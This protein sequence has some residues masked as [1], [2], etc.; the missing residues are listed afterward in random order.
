[1]ASPSPS[2]LLLA[3]L[4]LP[5][6]AVRLK[7]RPAGRK[8][9]M[10]EPAM[11]AGLGLL[12][13]WA[14]FRYPG[15]RPG[16]LVRAAVHGAVS[17]AGF[18]L[19]PATLSFLLPFLPSHALQ[20]YVVPSLLIATLTYVLLSWVWLIA[21]LVDDLLGG[22]PRGGI[23]FQASPSTRATVRQGGGRRPGRRRRGNPRP[24]L[25][26]ASALALLERSPGLRLTLLEKEADL[27]L[28]QSG[29]NSGVIHAG[30]YYPP[31]SLKA[32]FWREGR[33][34]LEVFCQ[35]HAVP[36]RRCGKFVV[37]IDES[38]L[39][40]LAELNRRGAANG[41]EGL[42][43]LDQAGMRAI[44]PHVR[45]IRGLHA[46]ETQLSTFVSSPRGWPTS[47]EAEAR[48]SNL[49]AEAR[50]RGT[51]TLRLTSTRRALDP[52]FPGPADTIGD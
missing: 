35:K 51:P 34:A 47:Y 43:E 26:L 2:P 25:G 7:S 24:R 20:P 11:F 10:L 9:K 18:A 33:A 3:S 30:L 5:P 27:A 36:L 42:T 28:H 15:L 23:P 19:L 44:E 21:R 6:Y 37:A 31:G 38:E 50:G 29:H 12:P 39:D 14:Y 41:L 1:V 45:G 17:F 13:V 52:P 48:S 8:G 40:R 32:S 49:H 16:S 4:P 22:T 46:P